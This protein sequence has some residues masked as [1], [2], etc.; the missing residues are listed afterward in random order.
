[1]QKDLSRQVYGRF[2][3]WK[4]NSE[5]KTLEVTGARQVGKTYLVKKF[6]AEAYSRC[7]YI[8]LLELSGEIFM[9][10]YDAIYQEIL[11]G[12]QI[13]NPVKELFTRHDPDFS[14]TEDTVIIIDEIQESAKIYNRIREFTRMLNCDV[15]VT[16]SY[17]GKILN[18]EFKYSSGDMT[19]ISI[20]TLS[21]EEFL[22]AAGEYDLY[23]ELDL[24]GGSEQSVYVRLGELYKVYCRIGGYPAVVLNYLKNRSFDACRKE[25]EGIIGL[26]TNESRRY[27]EDI[28]DDETYA[29]LFCS[30]ARVLVREKKGLEKDSFSEELQGIVAKEYSSNLS[31]ASVNRAI[32]WLYS[33]GIIGFVGKVIECS[34][35]DFR[36][37]A[38]CYFLDMGIAT[39]FLDRIACF[40]SGRDGMLNENFVYLDLK[41]RMDDNGELSFE[42]PAFA[43]YQK[44]EL[45]FFTVSLKSRK[46][47]GIEVKS[48]KNPGR[49][50]MR[51]LEDG[52]I[53]TAV[54]VKGN[55]HG[56]KAAGMLTIPIYGIGK[57]KF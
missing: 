54:L 9:E 18:R 57:F 7:I 2:W 41:R 38:R 40:D 36:A 1:M 27:F 44:G 50:I 45:D 31:K 21:F 32:D 43:T 46:V 49:T 56:G 11:S 28:L 52:K 17:L 3:E 29:N 8:N 15:I 30:I 48:G 10:R 24:Y 16:G 53:D 14:D 34:T 19:A 5:R 20:R 35:L 6:A 22:Q 25:L 39:Y 37:K 4:N 12:K 51:A 55:T 42:M 33:S 26:F 13:E 47:Y 23:E